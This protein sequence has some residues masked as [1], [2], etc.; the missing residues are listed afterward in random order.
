[1][2]V[3]HVLW[4]HNGKCKEWLCGQYEIMNWL[5]GCASND[6]AWYKVG[7]SNNHYDDCTVS[8]LGANQTWVAWVHEAVGS[9]HSSIS[10][11]TQVSSNLKAVVRISFNCSGP[12]ITSPSVQ[13]EVPVLTLNQPLVEIDALQFQNGLTVLENAVEDVVNEKC[14]SVIESDQWLCNPKA[15][16]LF[17]IGTDDPDKLF[18]LWIAMK[19]NN[20]QA[21]KDLLK[22]TGLRNIKKKKK[23]E[24]DRLSYLNEF[25]KKSN[26]L[27]ASL[28]TEIA[29]E[30]HER[31]E[32][33]QEQL[34]TAEIQRLVDKWFLNKKHLFSQ[35]EIQFEDIKQQVLE[36]ALDLSNASMERR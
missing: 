16:S 25:H 26:F 35:L 6:C 29:T 15:A 8:N 3:V 1:M 19:T 2:S 21:I 20:S 27:P 36:S 7:T 12:I 23:K 32:K 9:D 31:V 24:S 33:K 34:S 10:E 13:K 11:G 28:W 14:K 4:D 30:R 18:L 5:F 17:N 22:D